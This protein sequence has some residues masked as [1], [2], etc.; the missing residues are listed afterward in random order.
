MENLLTNDFG[1]AVLAGGASERMGF[2]KALLEIDGEPLVL[3]VLN[4]L[5]EAGIL[6][7]K[8]VGG[9]LDSYSE[10]GFGFIEDTY[11]GEGPLAGIITALDHYKNLD[12]GHVFIL[13][14]DLPN[15]SSSFIN[16]MC[17]ESLEAPE[18]IVIPTSNGHRQRM[19]ASWPVVILENLIESFQKGVRA[20][21]R[22]C[23]G[24]PLL[25]IN[26]ADKDYLVDVDSPQD[27]A[28]FL[29]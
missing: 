11:P 2:N 5:T 25:E 19:H 22:A 23:E 6:D 26:L 13:A 1:G 8:I 10:F 20:P 27:I 24:L 7:S 17:I 4:S 29:K 9:D 16:Q 12:K 28:R 15:V 21:W 3:K 14:C 18:S